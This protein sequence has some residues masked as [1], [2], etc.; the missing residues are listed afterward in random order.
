M[1]R[2][3]GDRVASHIDSGWDSRRQT[4]SVV[5]T[6]GVAATE[7]PVRWRLL[8]PDETYTAIRAAAT[9]AMI[10]WT[11]IRVRVFGTPNIV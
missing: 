6:R 11:R 8:R 10:R 7:G 1:P 3:Y 4:E 5:H 2:E 9:S